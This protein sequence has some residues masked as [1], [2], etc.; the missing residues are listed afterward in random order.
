MMA[1]QTGT[2]TDYRD[3]MD[4]LV[5]FITANGWT[6]E[7]NTTVAVGTG[8]LGVD[9]TNNKEI[10][11]RGDGGGSKNIYWGMTSFQD[12][13]TGYYNLQLRAF[14]GFNSG[15]SFAAQPGKSPNCYVPLQNTSMTYWMFVTGRRVCAVIKTGT[16]YQFLYAGFIDTYSTDE[17]DEYP[18]PMCVMGS[19]DVFNRAFSSNSIGFSSSADP[20]SAFSS[21]AANTSNA[22]GYLRFV[23]GAWYPIKN[24]RGTTSFGADFDN[25][26]VVN[27]WPACQHNTTGFSY[28]DRVT[29][30]H[31]IQDMF[32]NNSQGGAPD[33]NLFRTENGT[34]D[35]V[36]PL[37]QCVLLMKN[38][39]FQL[40]GEL[41][42]I[43]WCSAVG[44]VTAEDLVTDGI[45][46]DDFIVFQNIH[47]TD[48]W[49][50]MAVKDE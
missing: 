41:H 24:F 43:Y 48:N 20:G 13:T 33:A 14:T 21:S 27:V 47:R 9:G 45:S 34:A 8:G 49:K 32:F 15:N 40:V 6:S 25:N 42:N 1:S 4:D 7:R 50:F 35:P 12:A 18:Y 23:D 30:T 38:P 37:F 16:S 22:P 5:T 31:S 46:T 10:I 36:V 2:S 29:G 28:V 3:F 39:S 17:A 19:T 11:V 44:G 26:P